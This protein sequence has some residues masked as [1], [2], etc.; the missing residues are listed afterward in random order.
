MS[1]HYTHLSLDERVQIEKHL[2]AGMSM[3]Q[4]ALRVG[5]S[6][7]TI[8]REVRRNGWRPSSTSAAYTPYRP[9]RLRT[10]PWTGLQ[11]RASIAHPK[12]ERR[13]LGSHRPTKMTTDWQVTYVRRALERGWAPQAISGRLSR[14]HPAD[15][16]RHVCAETLYAW[17]YATPARAAELA[18]YLPRGH[19]RRRRR[20]G[21]R[22]HS[23]RI[24][25]RVS[26][27]HRPQGCEDR[28]EF[29]HWEADSVI[30]ARGGVALHTE[31]ERTTRYYRASKVAA[32]TSTEAVAAQKAWF[33]TLPQAGRRS[34]T[35]DNGAEFHR[36][37]ELVDGLGMA[38]FF[39]DP[40]SAYQRGTNEHFNGVLRRYLPKG[41]SFEDLSEA[42]LD[43]IVEEINNRPL[44]VLRWATPAEAFQEQLESLQATPCCTSS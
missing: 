17:I 18:Q 32:A 9:K 33:E 1:A 2:D 19:K 28:S 29:G 40:Y 14:E 26:I 24:E 42:E 36:H 6:P 10:G 16:S 22:V 5:R 44:K 37:F 13:A 15:R 41:T 34:V 38:T 8:S 27:R 43:G 4:S 20:P 21:R 30:G 23:S 39:A 12:A 31:A 7:S 11:Y 35:M 25:R 3:R